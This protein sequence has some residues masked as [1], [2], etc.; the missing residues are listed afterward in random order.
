MFAGD[1]GM[2]A[3]DTGLSAGDV[4]MSAGDEYLSSVSGFVLR[5]L[6]HM[7]SSFVQDDK[8]GL[9]CILRHVDIQLY[10]HHLLKMPSFF[11]CI[12]LASLM[13]IRKKK[14]ESNSNETN[15]DLELRYWLG[16]DVSC[17]FGN[18]QT[19]DDFS[20]GGDALQTPPDTFQVEELLGSLAF[21]E[22]KT[23]EFATINKKKFLNMKV[24]VVKGSELTE[25]RD[26][27][28]DPRGSLDLG[29]LA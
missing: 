13:K 22:K 19:L 28:S 26:E 16:F 5:S 27:L 25:E 15:P 14:G 2:S 1:I 29:F 24:S 8:Y 4:G 17:L 18:E 9:I 12:I 23:G 7:D 10:Q 6:I 11:H 3:G 20:A 21:Q